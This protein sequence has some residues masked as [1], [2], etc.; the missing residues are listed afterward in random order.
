MDH[1]PYYVVDLNFPVQK[2]SYLSLM[3]HL[4]E[5]GQVSPPQ[6]LEKLRTLEAKPNLTGS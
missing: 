1:W 6:I 2:F 5:G 4:V 3:L